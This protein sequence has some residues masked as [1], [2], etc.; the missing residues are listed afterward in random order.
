[1]VGLALTPD[2]ARAQTYPQPNPY[3]GPGGTSTMHANAASSGATSHCG[4]GSGAVTVSLQNY[5]PCSHPS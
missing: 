5:T 3:M 4:P 1:M 2:V